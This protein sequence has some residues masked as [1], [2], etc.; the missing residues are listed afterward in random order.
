ME[1]GVDDGVHDDTPK[2]KPRHPIHQSPKKRPKRSRAIL[3][4]LR[5]PF[6]V[7]AIPNYSY[8]VANLAPDILPLYRQFLAANDRDKIIP[9]EVRDEVAAI[10]WHLPRYFWDPNPADSTGAQAKAVF[11]SLRAINLSAAESQ[12]FQR[13]ECSWNNLVH[14]P[15]PQLAFGSNMLERTRLIPLDGS[16]QS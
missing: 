3:D 15:L 6:L 5:K 7:H 10:E 2:P 1:A 8:A 16:R 13:H 12:T 11:N 4:R 9:Y 14:T